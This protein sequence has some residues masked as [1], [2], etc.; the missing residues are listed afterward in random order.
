VRHQ[1]VWLSVLRSLAPVML[2][3]GMLNQAVS[4]C[5][6]LMGTCS[7]SPCGEGVKHQGV[8]PF[9]GRTPRMIPV[10]DGKSEVGND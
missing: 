2:F 1:G 5:A 7:R 3:P 9:A 8:M 4:V 6:W 10:L